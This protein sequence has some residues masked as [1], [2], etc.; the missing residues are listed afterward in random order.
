VGLVV[1]STG[2]PRSRNAERIKRVAERIRQPGVWVTR[3]SVVL[4]GMGDT[5]D[6]AAGPGQT[7]LA[8]AVRA[9]LDML[10]TPVIVISMAR[11]LAMAIIDARLRAAVVHAARRPA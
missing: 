8:A 10:L 11:L 1:L 4:S 5:T 6:D 2:A 3:C 7:R 9:R